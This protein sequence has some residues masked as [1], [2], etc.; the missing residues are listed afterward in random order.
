MPASHPFPRLRW[1]AL[2]WLV[3]YVPTYWHAYGLVN[4]LF[5]CNLG[6][7]LTALALWRE[8]TLLL[9]SQAVGA[10]LVCG[11]W[12]LDAGWRLL[13]GQHLIGGTE[14]MWDP[15]YPLFQRLLS[16]YHVAWPFVLVHALR[17]TG[18]DR[19]GWALQGALAAGAISASRLTAPALNINF[20]WVD[21]ILHRAFE[22]AWLH[23]AIVIGALAGVAYGL[24]HAALCLAFR[25]PGASDPPSRPALST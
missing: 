19:R 7:L 24:T 8:Q 14:Y 11:A 2:A 13:S 16:L 17:K 9:S 5:L 21:P 15:Q 22:P 1:L 12:M 18:Y 25:P 6:V 20:A 3:V 23:L 10:P 4:F